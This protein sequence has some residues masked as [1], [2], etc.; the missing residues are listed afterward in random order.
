MPSPRK[1]NRKPDVPFQQTPEWRDK[2][3]KVMSLK[4]RGFD[5][6][7]I[8]AVSLI[9]CMEIERIMEDETNFRAVAKANYEKKIPLLQDVLGSGLEIIRQ[10]FKELQ[11]PEVR[12]RMI[13]KVSDIAAVK[14]VVNDVA[15][16]LR[17]EEG[18]STQNV[19]S[20]VTHNYQNTRK[21][22]SDLR[23]MDP[24]FDYPV[25]PEG[26]SEP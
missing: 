5:E 25:L 10:C 21:A 22:L 2:V 17:L 12:R 18:K 7:Q 26:K 1:R 14:T 24:I 4:Q 11:D 8:A 6:K 16:L 23:K 15:M 9:P 13:T 3:Q 19:A 20:S